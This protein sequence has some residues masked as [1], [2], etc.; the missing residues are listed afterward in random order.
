MFLFRFIVSAILVFLIA[1]FLPGVQVDGFGTSLI[2]ALVLGLLNVFFRPL[3]LLLT[4]P[5]TLL[6]F[7]LFI[8]V[9]N[10]LVIMI[11]DFIVGGFEVSGFLTAV[12][13]SLILSF[14]Q[15]LVFLAAKR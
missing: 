8:L 2:V 13:F 9:I 15:W 11:C 3:M 10:G 5:V 1:N 6:T 4:L 7:G 12:L 14:F